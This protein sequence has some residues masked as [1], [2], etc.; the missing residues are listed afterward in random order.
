[1]VNSVEN[2]INY[3]CAISIFISNQDYLKL[4]RNSADYITRTRTMED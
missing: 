1:M 4:N 3:Y 2:T